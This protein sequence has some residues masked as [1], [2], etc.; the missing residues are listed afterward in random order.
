MFDCY[1]VLCCV[2]VL[3][4][5]CV[6]TSVLWSL[7]VYVL[8]FVL[9]CYIMWF[10]VCYVLLFYVIVNGLTDDSILHY[11]L[12][13]LYVI[14]Y[15]YDDFMFC[16]LWSECLLCYSSVCVRCLWNDVCILHVLCL[17]VVVFILVQYLPP[18]KK[19]PCLSVMWPYRGPYK[20]PYRSFIRSLLGAP[21]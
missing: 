5:T 6:C 21:Y 1:M 12:Q 8:G 16:V 14:C 17:T 10:A 19:V 9:T 4:F 7:C 3:C 15:R 13:C 18:V 20:E 11:M 2:I